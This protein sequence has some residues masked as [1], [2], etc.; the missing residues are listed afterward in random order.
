MII[1]TIGQVTFVLNGDFDF[2]FISDY[3]EPFAVFDQQDSGNLCF[4]VQGRDGKRFLKMAGARTLR[5]RVCPEEAV[6]RLKSTVE[7]YEA[8][9]HPKLIRLIGQRAIDGGH[10]LVFDWFEGKCMGKQYDS[11]DR[12]LSL[13]A[14]EKLAIYQDILEFHRHV[15]DKGYVAIDFYDGCIM[16]DFDA[17]LTMLCDIE[18]YR[19]M[20]VINHMGRMWGSTRYMSPEEFEMGAQIDGR[21]NVFMV[22]A[23][24]FNLFGGEMDRSYES[25]GLSKALFSIASKATSAQREARYAS[26]GEFMDAWNGAIVTLAPPVI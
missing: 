9:H 7:V 14:A 26:I 23:T 15:N 4:G 24:A 11:R 22:G 19:K 10:V 8:L 18:L 17:R 25:W 21:S 20:P 16:Y 6:D 1:K 2:S 13:P 3:G 5:S 12:F